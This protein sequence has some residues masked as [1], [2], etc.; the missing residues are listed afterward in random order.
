MQY[1]QQKSQHNTAQVKRSQ[2]SNGS[3]RGGN[4][5]RLVFAVLGLDFKLAALD[6]TCHEV[7]SYEIN[8]F[9]NEGKC[10]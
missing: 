6:P 9:R 8:A 3:S 5:R 1:T 4:L 7:A 2:N 10:C